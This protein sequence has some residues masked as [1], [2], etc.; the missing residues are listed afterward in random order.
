MFR[1]YAVEIPLKH[2]ARNTYQLHADID[3]CVDRIEPQKYLSSSLDPSIP[4]RIFPPQVG[5]R[6]YH[7]CAQLK[8]VCPRF[9][10]RE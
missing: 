8:R 10:G 7:K 6:F 4:Y 2:F 3:D 1:V 9:S 5:V